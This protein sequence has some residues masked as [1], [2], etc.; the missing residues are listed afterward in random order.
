MHTTS[1]VT[2]FDCASRTV[3][4]NMCKCDTSK[5]I[6]INVNPLKTSKTL[7]KL[8]KSNIESRS[9]IQLKLKFSNSSRN[10]RLDSSLSRSFATA[11]SQ[12]WWSQT[13]SNRRPPACKAGA[14]P[15]ELWPHLMV[16]LGRFEL[17]TSPLSGVRSNQL[18]YRP[19]VSRC[20][21]IVELRSRTVAD[22][23]ITCE[24]ARAFILEASFTL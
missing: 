2:L 16:G 23:Q 4:C 9:A 15:A 17:P 8:L 21:N 18:S 12:N 6:H 13:G 7:S 10:S 19:K 11:L 24:G 22:F 3:S 14:L 20:L 5:C 1:F